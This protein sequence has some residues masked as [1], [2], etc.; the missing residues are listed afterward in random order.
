M[1]VIYTTYTTITPDYAKELL[2]KNKR[3]RSLNR[4]AIER[5]ARDMKKNNWQNNGESIKIDWDGNLID[6]QHRL[7]AC[8]NSGVSFDSA[9]VSGLNPESFYTIDTGKQRAA[10]DI[11]YIEGCKYPQRVA[12]AARLLWCYT[13]LKTTAS[14]CSNTCTN[15]EIMELVAKNQ[16][17]A[18]SVTICM[19]RYSKLAKMI[20]AGVASFLFYKFSQIDKELANN[21]FSDLAFGTNLSDDDVTYWVREKLIQS[22]AN[23]AYWN[24]GHK[25]LVFSRLW[26]KLRKGQ[27]KGRVSLAG[28]IALPEL[29]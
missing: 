20:G 1:K 18:E 8:I 5:Y 27:T 12:T 19:G 23:R 17:L 24:Q 28:D 10:R 6:G 22:K 13:F 25:V 4:R 14:L 9:V 16:G 29:I 11:L 15:S 3:N 21:L 7:N 2:G 26:N